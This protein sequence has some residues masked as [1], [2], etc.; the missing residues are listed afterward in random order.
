MAKT[1]TPRD[2]TYLTVK[3]VV[4]VFMVAV[5]VISFK[6]IINLCTAYQVTTWQAWTAPAFVDGFVLLG[7]VGGQ[8]RFASETRRMALRL[9][10]GATLVS[11]AA[12]VLA[13]HTVGDRVYGGA[14]VAAFLVAEWFSLHMKA[15]PTAAEIKAVEQAAT[16]KAAQAKATATRK[17]NAAAEAAR[18]EAAAERRRLARALKDTEEMTKTFAETIAPISPAVGALP[19][20]YL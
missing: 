16:R 9:R 7:I 14:V 11:L 18:K 1:K 13:G 6:H 17:A 12:N 8:A 20:T 10:I 2:W 15:A 4:R 19:T 5:L 3:V